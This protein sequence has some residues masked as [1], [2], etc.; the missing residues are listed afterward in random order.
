CPNGWVGYRG[1]CYFLSRDQGSWDQGQAR[2]SELW[3]SLAMLK[4][5]GTVIPLPPQWNVD[6]WLRLRRRGQG[7]H[8]GYG[9]SFNSTGWG[10]NIFLCS[11]L[12][13]VGNAVCVTLADNKL[14]SGTCSNPWPYLC[15][16]AQTRL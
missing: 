6:Y 1:V 12:Q 5:E 7:L 16:G 11:S 9:S 4:D 2:Y 10:H 3:V 14:R 15:S 8:W 13:V